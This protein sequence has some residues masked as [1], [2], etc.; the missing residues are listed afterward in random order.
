MLLVVIGSVCGLLPAEVGATGRTPEGGPPEPPNEI[1]QRERR[2]LLAEK[3]A[4]PLADIEEV[5]FAAHSPGREWHFF[6]TT[7][8]SCPEPAK[9]YW[10]TGPALLCAVNLR[11]RKIRT[12]YSEPDATLRDPALCPD[13][14]EVVYSFRAPGE[15]VFHLW[16]MNSDGGDRTQLTFGDFD[17]IEPVY[18]PPAPGGEG[19]SGIVFS[20]ARCKRCFRHQVL[21][22]CLEVAGM[23]LLRPFPGNT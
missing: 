13:A 16:E 21:L 20:S 11:S 3:L 4:G 12:I 18:L 8:Y 19:P 6:A 5:L 1:V 15:K 2:G 10:P 14:G 23:I 7:G 17:D 22:P 9:E